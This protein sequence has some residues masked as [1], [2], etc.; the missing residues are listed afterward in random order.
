MPVVEP[1]DHGFDTLDPVDFAFTL[2]LYQK[3]KDAKMTPPMWVT[4]LILD[5]DWHASNIVF[6]KL[7]FFLP[8]PLLLQLQ[9]LTIVLNSRD[10]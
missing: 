9:S 8:F 1:K 4:S 5:V 2:Q 3:T 7:L 6:P 10:K